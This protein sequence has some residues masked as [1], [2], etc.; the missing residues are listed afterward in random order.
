MFLMIRRCFRIR[1][2]RLISFPPAITLYLLPPCPPT[3]IS[4]PQIADVDVIGFLV[5]EELVDDVVVV[6][7]AL[8]Y[9]LLAIQFGPDGYE[10]GCEAEE[11]NVL[12]F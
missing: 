5:C 4:I 9:K 6:P 8:L 11:E 12:T 10:P 2:F 7:H 3:H 1:F